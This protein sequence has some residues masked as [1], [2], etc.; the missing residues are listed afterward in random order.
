MKLK[1]RFA[2]IAA[3]TTPTPV[4]GLAMHCMGV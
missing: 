3:I 1:I 2:E 4:V